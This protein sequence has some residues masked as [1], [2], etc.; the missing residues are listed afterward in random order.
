MSSG[1]D[2]G[3]RNPGRDSQLQV[4]AAGM[5]RVGVKQLLDQKALQQGGYDGD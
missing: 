2:D 5:R 1:E 3:R 4:E